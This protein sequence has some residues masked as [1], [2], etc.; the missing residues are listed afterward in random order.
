MHED[1]DL[2][3][4]CMQAFV[5]LCRYCE[6]EKHPEFNQAEEDASKY[7]TIVAVEQNV[8]DK[9]RMHCEG[10]SLPQ[11]GATNG[12]CSPYDTLVIGGRIQSVDSMGLTEAAP[13]HE[14]YRELASGEGGSS[15]REALWELVRCDFP[16]SEVLTS[17]ILPV[18]WCANQPEY[19]TGAVGGGHSGPRSL[20]EG[21]LCRGGSAAGEGLPLQD[22]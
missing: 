4:S 8:D 3:V 22:A 6:P 15:Q 14:L 9:N 18:H 19:R 11:D 1:A 17:P 21:R 7:L 13:N 5:Q 10:Y 16:F 2:R 12:I 20:P